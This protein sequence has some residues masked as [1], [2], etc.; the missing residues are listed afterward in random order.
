MVIADFDP[1]EMTARLTLQAPADLPDGQGGATAG[2]S[3]VTALWARIVPLAAVAEERAGADAVTVTHNVWV[4]HR[5][6]LAAGMRLMKGGRVFA[7]STVR[8]PDETGRYLICQCT[9][10][11]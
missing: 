10:E 1:G 3:D 8:D 2:F 11:G 6:D 4:R 5:A 9:E 7:V